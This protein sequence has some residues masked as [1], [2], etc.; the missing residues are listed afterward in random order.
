MLTANSFSKT[1]ITK[2]LVP[3]GSRPVRLTQPKVS[4]QHLNLQNFPLQLQVIFSP[5]FKKLF[6]LITIDLGLTTLDYSDQVSTESVIGPMRK[7]T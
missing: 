2:A 7:L 1:Q 6:L 5:I 4:L 3:L